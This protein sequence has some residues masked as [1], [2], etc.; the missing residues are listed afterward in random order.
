MLPQYRIGTR[1]LCSGLWSCSNKNRT[2]LAKNNGIHYECIRHKISGTNLNAT[3]L[4]RTPLWT[5]S[6]QSCLLGA[7]WFSNFLVSPHTVQ[8]CIIN[9]Q[10]RGI[11]WYIVLC[12]F[13]KNW[14]HTIQKMCSNDLYVLLSSTVTIIVLKHG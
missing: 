13:Y 2:S 11:I 10:L 9:L 3:F 4:T 1:V 14:I 12:C 8:K 7:I 5:Q 6:K